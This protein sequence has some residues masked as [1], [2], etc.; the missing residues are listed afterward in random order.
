MKYFVCRKFCE[1]CNLQTSCELRSLIYIDFLSNGSSHAEV[2]SEHQQ[3]YKFLYKSI[4][5][6]KSLFACRSLSLR[7]SEANPA[8]AGLPLV[9]LARL[10]G[11]GGEV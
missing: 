5:Y 1:L 2:R 4:T 3:T 10:L 8:Y 6:V 7:E 9:E 11:S